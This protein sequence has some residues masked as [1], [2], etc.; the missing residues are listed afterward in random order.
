V[1]TELREIVA[2]RPCDIDMS[3]PVWAFRPAEHKTAYR[4][5]ERVVHFGPRA[6]QILRPFVADRPTTAYTP[7]R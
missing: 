2:L 5:H 1:A 3:G 7:S 6:Q 4:G